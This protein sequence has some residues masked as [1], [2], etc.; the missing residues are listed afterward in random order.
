MY[1]HCSSETDTIR[2]GCTNWRWS[3]DRVTEKMLIDN[4]MSILVTDAR[5]GRR[6]GMIGAIMK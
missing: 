3:K 4:R 1:F 2:S 5:M 6:T